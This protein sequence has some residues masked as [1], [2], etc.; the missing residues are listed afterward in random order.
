MLELKDIDYVLAVA[1]YHNVSQAAKALFISQPALSKYIAN[2]ENRL[3]IPLFNRGGKQL[4]LTDAGEQYIKYA[5]EIS[6]SAEALRETIRQISAQ[7][8]SSL[9]VGVVSSS[10]QREL[11][12]VIND[13]MLLYPK[14]TFRITDMLS[15]ELEHRVL[16]NLLHLG[17]VIVPPQLS[18][19]ESVVI[20]RNY[21]L[22]A[23]PAG[24]PLVKRGV[25]H[26]DLPFPW[27]DLH[28]FEG[29]DYIIQDKNCRM[30]LIA[31]EVFRQEGFTPKVRLTTQSTF[32]AMEYASSG[33]G[34]C[35]ITD[36]Y[37]PRAPIGGNLQFFC[38]GEP[39]AWASFGIVYRKGTALS[40][41]AR[42]FIRLC[43]A[44]GQRR[45]ESGQNTKG[46]SDL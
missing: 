13:L 24:N 29:C 36:D 7:Q 31:D 28:Y 18:G 27:I 46:L 23:V 25:V 35:M 10:W 34:V 22:L 8:A 43:K 17:L 21:V 5:K 3:G 32:S 42:D 12:G 30:R 37:I 26:E 4:T 11:P 38:V 41:L 19:L 2:L 9:S 44:A 45:M 39:V 16:N 6:R 20:E 1:Q 15:I 40:P 14:T 33:I